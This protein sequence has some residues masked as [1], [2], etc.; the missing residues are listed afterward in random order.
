MKRTLFFFLALGWP[1]PTAARQLP[2][3]SGFAPVLAGYLRDGLVDY[4]GLLADRQM[5]DGYVAELG[6][7]TQAAVDAA[8][9]EQQL[10]FW[11]NAYNACV[12]TLVLDHYPIEK[13]G[14]FASIL[15]SVKGYPGNSVQQIPDTWKRSFCNIAGSVRSLDEIEHEIIRP[16]GEPRIHFAIN[17][18]AHSCP[19]LAATPYTPQGLDGQ[20]DKQVVEFVANPRHFLLERGGRAELRLNKVLD[21]FGDDFGGNEGLIEFFLPY[22]SDEDRTYLESNG[23][24]KVSFFDYDWTLNDTAIADSSS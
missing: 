19:P 4:A 2:D 11:I 6:K 1:A 9:S 17:C 24:A 8:T 23:P 20:L 3:H 7:P 13:R 15:N 5:L 14:G 21:W 18:A 12:L 16:M 10:A 22:L